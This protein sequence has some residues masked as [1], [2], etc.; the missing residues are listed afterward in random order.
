LNE[1]RARQMGFRPPIAGGK[2]SATLTR[3]IV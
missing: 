2:R 3:Q 1:R